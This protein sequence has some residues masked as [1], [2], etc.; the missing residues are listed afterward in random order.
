MTVPELDQE[1]RYI[2]ECLRGDRQDDDAL[3]QVQVARALR[4]RGELAPHL[5]LLLDLGDQ[6]HDDERRHVPLDL[7]AEQVDVDLA[8]TAALSDRTRLY[9]S[10]RLADVVPQRVR[11]LWPS[12]LPRG[13]LV[14]LDGDPDVGKSTVMLDLVA[15]LT[16]GRPMPGEDLA[17]IPASDVVLLA[18]EDGLADTIRPRLDAAGAD[19]ARVH[20]LDAVPAYDDEGQVMAWVPPSIPEDITA[21]EALIEETSAVL[22]VVDVL[23]AYLS[24][25]ADSHRDQDVRRALAQLADIAERTGACVVLVRH[26]RKSRGSAMYAGGG[27]VGIIGVARAG[28]IAAVD[29]DDESGTR[30]VLARAK[31]NL[32][33]PYPSLAYTL[34][35]DMEGGSVR[36]DW[37]GESAHTGDQ[38]LAPQPDAD[39]RDK[40][41]GA[42]E[43]L[44][45]VLAD[46]PRKRAEIIAEGRP[47]GY[48]EKMIERA[49]K[50]LG[51]VSERDQ[52]VQGRPATW[53]L[54]GYPTPVIR[55]A[56]LSDN[57][58]A[59]DQGKQAESDG[60]PTHPDGVGKP[61]DWQA[62]PW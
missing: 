9:R 6:L 47:E 59:P 25:R 32:A 62:D 8:T 13:K 61:R 21:L 56:T 12:R 11:W 60:F 55:Q 15:R 1:S 5:S 2:V 3:R 52:Q 20:H 7:G 58:Q 23:M 29:P 19:P 17:A 42:V 53:T 51:V 27:S 10:T 16:T 30:R 48:G 50:R 26:L 36:V 24:G 22:V 39:E 33:P 18:A 4:D 38:L 57:T 45:E 31:G 43:W 28:M 34:L 41:D 40:I 44:R 14:V 49:A 54:P 37:L 46:R 35:A